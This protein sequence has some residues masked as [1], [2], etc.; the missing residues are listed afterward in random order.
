MS[1]FR[2]VLCVVFSLALTP[3]HRILPKEDSTV[4]QLILNIPHPACK[5]LLSGDYNNELW[6]VNYAVVAILG[7]V[8]SRI[9]KQAI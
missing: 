8:P 5:F 4:I 3:E 2:A 9:Y 1:C 7:P 6:I